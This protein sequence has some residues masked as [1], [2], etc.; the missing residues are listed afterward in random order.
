MGLS[1]GLA[2]WIFGFPDRPEGWGP[3]RK[4]KIALL[5]LLISALVLMQGPLGRSFRIPITGIG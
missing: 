2:E 5:T 3:S 4:S 1:D